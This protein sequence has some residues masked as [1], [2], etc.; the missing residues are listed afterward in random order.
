[1]S[2]FRLKVTLP[3]FPFS[4]SHL[5][6]VMCI[7]SCFAEHMFRQLDQ[8]KFET[9]LNPFGILYNPMVIGE[10][11][12]RLVSGKPFQEEDLVPNNELWHSFSHHGRFSAP[13]KEQTLSDI[14]RQMKE[15]SSFLKKT[16]RLI[17]TFGTAQVY[18]LKET[19]KIVANCHKFP[20]DYFEKRLLSVGEVVKTLTSTFSA[21]KS[22]NPKLEIILSVSPIRH[23]RDG[24]IENQRSK[25]TLLLAVAE[26]CQN[27]PFTHYFPS[28]EVVMDELRDYRFFEKDM[29]HPNRQ[30]IDYIWLLF[31]RAFFEDNTQQLT[32]SIAKILQAAQHRAFHPQTK[33]HQGFLKHQLK[34]VQA[35]EKQYAFLNFEKEIT[36]FNKNLID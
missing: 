21:L 26:I 13:E 24:L 3:D 5:D 30:A 27:L 9:N 2:D 23:Y 34:K 31:V 11:L 35:L 29:V 36:T 33:A 18:T 28:Y 7:G 32:S 1:M 15:G 4:I 17:L 22:I 10:G 20:A 19:G 6:R 8:H 14:N 12:R 25:A 16:T